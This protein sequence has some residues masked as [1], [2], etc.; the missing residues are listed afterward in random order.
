MEAIMS[1][2]YTW[3]KL[4]AAVHTLATGT[5][6]LKNRLADAYISALVRLEPSDFPP[7]S[8]AEFADFRAA[9]VRV[10]PQGDEGRVAATVKDMPDEVAAH[11]AGKIV[12]WFDHVKRD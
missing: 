9:M 5:D 1:A 10:E 8:R 7:N 6:D 3:E 11:W 12:S 2:A 4:Y